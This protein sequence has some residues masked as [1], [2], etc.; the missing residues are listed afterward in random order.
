MVD[1]KT[2]WMQAVKELME[3]ELGIIELNEDERKEL[4]SRVL[5]KRTK[6]AAVGYLGR[7]YR[8]GIL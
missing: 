1:L 3:Y 2:Q 7:K 5:N 6:G 8:H 4:V